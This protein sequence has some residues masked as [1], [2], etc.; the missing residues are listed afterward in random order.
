MMKLVQG[1]N[2]RVDLTETM[3]TQQQDVGCERPP[4]CDG[5]VVFL[6]WQGFEQG[7]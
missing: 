4:L 2:W 5:G 7:G 3:V 1:E 6:G